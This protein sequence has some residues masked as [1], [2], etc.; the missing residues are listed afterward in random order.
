MTPTTLAELR[1]RLATLDSLEPV[2]RIRVLRDLEVV[3][4]TI[5]ADEAALA[6]LEATTGPGPRWR[7]VDLA[8]ELDIHKNKVSA[9]RKR[10]RALLQ[11]PAAT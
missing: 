9:G 11:A 3:T 1:A 4:R 5:Y 8:A 10:A 7:P 2:E 6:M